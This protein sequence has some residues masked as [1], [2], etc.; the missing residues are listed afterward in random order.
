M[1]VSDPAPKFS[2][3]HG[4]VI[5]ALICNAALSG[6]VSTAIGAGAVAATAAS[7][8]R[9]IG[10]AASDFAIKSRINGL[11]LDA[12]NTLW[13]N[14]NI[15]VS[16]GRVLLTGTVKDPA[17]KQEAVRLAGTASGV[18][19]II[20]E[21]EVTN[22]KADFLQDQLITTRLRERILLDGD[23]LSIN[24][25]ISTVNQTVYLIGIAQDAAEIQR[26]KDHARHVPR[27][28]RIVDH[29]LLK[30]DPRR[31]VNKSA[32]KTP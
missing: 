4:V 22:A 3:S 29:V 25:S 28:R 5:F 21:I 30:D 13:S 16:E 10:G 23:V 11:F 31:P 14:I 7:E 9:G 19:E 17:Q 20:D 8:E 27:V 6:C 1:P 24:Y 15:T 32:G 26:V 2:V 18:R 12:D